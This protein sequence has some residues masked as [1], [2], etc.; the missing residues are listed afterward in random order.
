MAPT[1]SRSRA[2]LRNPVQVAIPKG[3]QQAWLVGE[4]FG[5]DIESYASGWL[6][7]KSSIEGLTGFFL[8]MDAA[9]TVL[10]GADLPAI[11][12]QLVFHYL[13]VSPGFQTE[14]TIVNVSDVASQVAIE[15][16]GAANPPA[17]LSVV[18]PAKGLLQAS[19]TALFPT[20]AWQPGAYVAAQSEAD[21]AGIEFVGSPGADGVALN[22]RPASEQLRTLFF[23][24]MTVM[25]VI[26]RRSASPIPQQNLCS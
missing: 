7:A 16:K 20:A 10:D 6:E 19:A 12:K 8:F 17:P 14:L 23:P 21:M 5:S 25:E 9:A 26:A 4:L 2:G 3:Q 11:S 1:A 22:A 18:L 15:L 24:G 13:N